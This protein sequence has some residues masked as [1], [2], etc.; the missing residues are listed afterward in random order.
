MN[1]KTEAKIN[2]YFNNTIEVN[3]DM[4][5]YAID[6]K[7]FDDFFKLRSKIDNI[8]LKCAIKEINRNVQ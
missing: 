6:E 5:N 1:K 7:R 2:D 8:I 4:T 3:E